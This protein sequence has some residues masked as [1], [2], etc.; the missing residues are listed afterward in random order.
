[1][2]YNVHYN[3]YILWREWMVLRS[4]AHKY[5]SECSIKLLIFNPAIHCNAG[6][7]QRNV[8]F[9]PA[10]SLFW[11]FCKKV[12][13]NV[14]YADTFLQVKW[15]S[16]FISVHWSCFYLFHPAHQK[17]PSKKDLH[18]YP[19]FFY[20]G[21]CRIHFSFFFWTPVHILF[22]SIC[23]FYLFHLILK[24]LSFQKKNSFK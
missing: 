21:E 11:L 22:Y 17:I 2:S 15:N 9:F 6:P 10:N 7:F 13:I 19:E 3:C 1:M 18:F 20:F 12:S 4:N 23:T 14:K 5:V 16:S 8:S 24:L